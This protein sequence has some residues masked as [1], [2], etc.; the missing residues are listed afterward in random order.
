MKKTVFLV[1]TMTV[2]FFVAACSSTTTSPEAGQNLA[3]QKGCAACHSV[4]ETDK[5][6]PTWVGLYGSQV[7]LVDGTFVTADDE[8]LVGSI[9][10]PNV[11]IVKGFTK[12]SMPLVSLTDEEIT[13]IVA[14]I[15]GVK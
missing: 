11:K 4:D 9:E 10:D 3:V 1:F 2:F 13:A 14:Y 7:E 15:K 5:I 6:G 8:Y 12:G